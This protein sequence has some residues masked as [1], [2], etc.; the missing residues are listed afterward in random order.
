MNHRL[1]VKLVEDKSTP[2]KSKKY[3]SDVASCI[4]LDSNVSLENNKL[5]VK[6]NQHFT[7]VLRLCYF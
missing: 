2:Y 6:C 7:D 1:A 3:W 5:V 4:E